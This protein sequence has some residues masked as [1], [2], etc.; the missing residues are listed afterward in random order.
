MFL[1]SLRFA[2]SVDI[3]DPIPLRRLNIARF[4][5]LYVRA[6][7]ITDPAEALQY[8]FFLRNKRD[9]NGRNLFLCCVCDLAIE[10]RDYDLLFGKMQRTGVRSRGLIDQFESIDVDPRKACEMV[11]DELIKKGLF[12]DAIK[13]YDL[14]GI[15]EQCLRYLSI[16]LSQVVHQNSKKGSLRERLYLK[17]LEFTERYSGNDVHCDSKIRATFN[18]LRDLVRFFDEYNEQKHQSALNTLRGLQLVPLNV[19]ELDICVNNFKR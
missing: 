4:I 18:T 3:E 2:V 16:L 19:S 10:C 6:F 7:E 5:M 13:L 17:A 11:A 1:I 15:E 14:A 9:P 12:E 8:F